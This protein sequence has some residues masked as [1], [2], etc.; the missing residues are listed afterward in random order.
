MTRLR[1]T[2]CRRMTQTQ[3]LRLAV[4][5]QYVLTNE[6]SDVPPGASFWPSYTWTFLPY[7]RRLELHP[8][9]LSVRLVSAP[10]EVLFPFKSLQLLASYGL[11]MHY[12]GWLH[13]SHY[14][15]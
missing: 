9:D 2:H 11:P 4:R 12:S 3:Y 13:H 1:D 14:S 5:K 8:P 10:P 7:F 6:T 15:G